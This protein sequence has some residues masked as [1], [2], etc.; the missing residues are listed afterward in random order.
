MY[1]YWKKNITSE[2]KVTGKLSEE[3]FK[4]MIRAKEDQE[5]FY[6]IVV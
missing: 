3:G 4:N 5:G 2:L 1:I 6:K